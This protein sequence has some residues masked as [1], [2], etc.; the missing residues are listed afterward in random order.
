MLYS[1]QSKM[2]KGVFMCNKLQKII[3]SLYRLIF[4]WTLILLLGF[5]SRFNVYK[6]K[7]FPMENT[8]YLLL[9]ICFIGLLIS[10]YKKHRTKITRIINKNAYIIVFISLII[11]FFFQLYICYGGYFKSKWDAGIIEN[12][13][14]YEYSND[15][16]KIDN[17]YF[18]WY[19]NNKLIVWLYAKI[20]MFSSLISITNWE[21][22]LVCFQC[23]ID[24]VTMY[25]IY[26]VSLNLTKH[27]TTA[28]FTFFSGCAFIGIS[29]WFI[30]AYSDATSFFLPILLIRLYQISNNTNKKSIQYI[31][32]SLI[33]FL[34]FFSY[35]IKPQI[36]ICF[37]A[38]LL[39]DLLS[40][41]YHQFRKKAAVF[42]KKI[43]FYS[44]GII[45]CFCIY[46]YAIV[47]SLH[48][49]SNP[50][51]VTGWQHYLMMGMN[52]ENDGEFSSHD[53]EYTRSFETNEE[54][55]YMDLMKA[56]ERIKKMGVVGLIRHLCRKQIANYGDGTFA[57]NVEA[58]GITPDSPKW[59]KNGSSTIVRSL[60][61]H[62][63]THYGVFI[64]IKQIMWLIV[65]LSQLFIFTSSRKQSLNEDKSIMCMIISII[66]L[67]V[68]ELIFEARSRYFLC[69]SP[70]FVVLSGCAMRNVY[71]AINNFPAFRKRHPS[72]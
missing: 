39:V 63:G 5:Q 46:T 70:L 59:A 47:P 32:L 69:F 65:I 30:V 60:I 40:I 68:F 8:V 25:L 35:N 14:Y 37:I 52:N 2:I 20:I 58:G 28:L 44:M 71:N 45:L 31:I 38:I 16:S 50:D 43:L 72:T 3:I 24:A 36:I 42:T 1:E 62:D 64:S 6:S 13:A 21:Y 33:G 9:G 19:P 11:L 54:R 4:V 15:F 22:A 17:S 49:I 66:G 12:T 7:N 48:I 26:K 29:P 10:I 61:R 57:W 67:T 55:N 27:Q 56:E 41:N 18:S 51:T 34:T 53:V 23:C